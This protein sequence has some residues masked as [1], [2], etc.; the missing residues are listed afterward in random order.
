MTDTLSNRGFTFAPEREG[1]YGGYVRVSESSAASRPCVWVRAVEPEATGGT[2]PGCAA[3]HLTVEQALRFAEDILRICNNH[4][5][6]DTTG[7]LR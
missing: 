1:T 3:V 4:Y 5:Q 7:E 6:T 2:D